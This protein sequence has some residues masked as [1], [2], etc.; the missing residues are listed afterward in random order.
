MTV[1]FKRT[2]ASDVEVGDVEMLVV[3]EK[4]KWF[5][6]YYRAESVFIGDK[7]EPIHDPMT[8]AFVGNRTTNL[9][10]IVWTPINDEGKQ[11][12]RQYYPSTTLDIAKNLTDYSDLAQEEEATE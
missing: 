2:P 3:E 1:A 11:F 12:T 5:Y 9:V 4:R 10:E 6:Y 7:V 8:G